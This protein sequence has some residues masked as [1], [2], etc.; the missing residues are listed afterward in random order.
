MFLMDLFQPLDEAV[1]KYLQIAVDKHHVK[2]PD[3][4]TGEV[5]PHS[6]DTAAN[7]V[8]SG[9]VV[10]VSKKLS[11]PTANLSRLITSLGAVYRAILDSSVTHLVFQ[12]I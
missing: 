1:A 4:S 9:C 12:V 3:C 11:T 5:E 8:L 2:T 7:S 6:S 10:C